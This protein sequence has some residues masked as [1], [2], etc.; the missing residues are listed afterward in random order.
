MAHRDAPRAPAQIYHETLKG[1]LAKQWVSIDQGLLS[2][3]TYSLPEVWHVPSYYN[4]IGRNMLNCW[5]AAAPHREPP[6]LWGAPASKRPQPGKLVGCKAN[7]SW[8]VFLV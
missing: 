5:P 1:V 2:I 6:E 4:C 8:P 7:A 3:F